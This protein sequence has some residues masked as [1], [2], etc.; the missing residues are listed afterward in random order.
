MKPTKSTHIVSTFVLQTCLSAFTAFYAAQLSAAPLGTAFTYEGWLNEGTNVVNGIYDFRFSIYDSLAAGNVVGGP[1]TNAAVAVSNGLFKTALDFGANVFAGDARWLEIGVRAGTNAFTTLSP[2]QPV[3]PTPYALYSPNAGAAFIASNAAA[4][5]I[6]ASALAMGAVDSSH[7]ASA[8]IVASNLS[9]MVLS[10]TFWRLSGNSGTSASNF[11]GTRDYQT[12]ELKV[13]N[14][15]ALRIEPNTVGAPNLIGGAPENAVAAGVVGATIGGGGASGSSNYVAA[16]YGT[17]GGGSANTITTNARYSFIGGGNLNTIDFSSYSVIAGGWRNI[18]QSSYAG[19]AIGGGWYNSI[20]ND[21]FAVIGGGRGN[22]IQNNADKSTIGGGYNN[23]IYDDAQESTI[24]GGVGNY[25]LNGAYDSTIG[26]G[27]QNGIQPHATISTIG[28]GSGNS[29]QTDAGGSTISGGWA[30]VIQSNAWQSTIGGGGENYI[31]NDAWEC[32]IGG[33]GDNKVRNNSWHA[34]IP[35]GNYNEVAGN[36]SF[37]AGNYARALHDGTF[38]WSDRRFA[39]YFTSS[40]PNQ[41]LIRAYGGVGINTN[42]P[43]SAL[44]VWGTVTANDFIGET[45]TAGYFY[46]DGSHLTNVISVTTSTNADML[47]GYHESAFARAVHIHSAADIASGTL[48]SD[49]LPSS[50]TFSETVTAGAFVGGGS[51]L[52]GLNA[53]NLVSGTVPD[54]RLNSDPNFSGTVMA[55][56]LKIGTNHIL[57]GTRATIAGGMSNT[58]NGTDSIIGGGMFNTIRGSAY[59]GFIGGGTVNFISN[60]IANATIPGGTHNTVAADM[61]LAA[62]TYARASHHGSF[63]W[64]DYHMVDFGSTAPNQ[65]LIRAAGG[66]GINTNN[67]QSDLHVNGT[68]TITGTNIV[69]GHVIVNGTNTVKVLVIT[70][71]ADVA[72]PFQISEG[73]TPKGAVVVIDEENPGRLRMSDCAYDTKV[74]GIVSGANGVNPGISLRQDNLTAGGQN[75]ALSGRVYALA[76]ASNGPIQPGDLLTTSATPGHAMKVTNLAKAQGAILGKAM[77][78]LNNGKGMVL[79]LVSLQ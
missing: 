4:G 70:G 73:Q 30:N 72:E 56:R 46:G 58:N 48:N 63:V 22:I 43:Q 8:T 35:G 44:H 40:G 16:D 12:L 57:S 54:A 5:S 17:I 27:A 18:I 45:V 10:N 53:N 65:F 33:G 49:R 34:T 36:T 19:S 47:D 59:F 69:D 28:G 55:S 61:S 29:I 64:A 6:G 21:Y 67:P 14:A 1:L 39:E 2:R 75:V 37:A 25:I 11:L 3:T 62:G 7:I 74:A 52:T 15:R 66:V 9:P 42:N 68:V 78:G 51:G 50:A 71:G 23:S 41:F 77:T 38:V 31:Q 26:G 32:T 13:N 20:S 24:G 60:S 76:D 79:V